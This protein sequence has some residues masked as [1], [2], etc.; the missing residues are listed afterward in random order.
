MPMLTDR[1]PG[2]CIEYALDRRCND[3][4]AFPHQSYANK[5][6]P[7]QH[8][9]LQGISVGMLCCSTTSLG[10]VTLSNSEV[11]LNL[12]PPTLSHTETYPAL[13]SEL[14]CTVMR[15]RCLAQL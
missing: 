14:Q 5:A 12:A 3:C 8:L 9:L 6:N 11:V 2:L 1:T 7:L 13:H 4:I 15:F 10:D